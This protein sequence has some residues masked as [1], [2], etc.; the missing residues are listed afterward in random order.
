M[1]WSSLRC[2]VMQLQ[3]ALKMIESAG[4]ALWFTCGR[5]VAESG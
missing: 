5:K 4:Q 2:A 1:P 3:A